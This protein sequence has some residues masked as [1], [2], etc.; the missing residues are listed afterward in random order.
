MLEPGP[1]IQVEG[2]LLLQ[3]ELNRRQ[4]TITGRGGLPSKMVLTLHGVLLIAI[5]IGTALTNRVRIHSTDMIQTRRSALRGAVHLTE[6]E[7]VVDHV[8]ARL[9]VRDPTAGQG[10]GIN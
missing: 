3:G 5:A 10:A 4:T 6:V 2:F 1:R 9:P 7:E 8:R